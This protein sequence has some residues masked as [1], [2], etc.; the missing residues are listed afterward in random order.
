MGVQSGGLMGD[1][2]EGSL[3]AGQVYHIVATY[4]NNTARIYIDGVN[5]GNHT[6]NSPILGNSKNITIGSGSGIP[7][8]NCSMYVFRLYNRTLSPDEVWQ[9]YINDLPRYKTP[10]TITW[11]KP[12]DITYGTELSD[13]Q[14]NAVAKDSAGNTID[15]SKTYTPAAGTVLSAGTHTQHVDFTPNDTANYNNATANVTLN[16]H[17]R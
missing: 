8:G 15:G 13:I 14:L 3:V 2:S 11:S 7:N 17:L 9:N 5:S 16:M 12:A 6:W 1:K 4:D 10:S